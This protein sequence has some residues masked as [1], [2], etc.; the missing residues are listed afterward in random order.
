MVLDLFMYVLSHGAVLMS[1]C[2]CMCAGACAGACA[3]ACAC[4]GV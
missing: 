2:T 3:C 1:L 4:T